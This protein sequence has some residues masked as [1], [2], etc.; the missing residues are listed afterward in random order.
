MLQAWVFGRSAEDV[1]KKLKEETEAHGLTAE[2]KN[3]TADSHL[4]ARPHLL[5]RVL[6]LALPFYLEPNVAIWRSET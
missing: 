2:G 6:N 4:N 5:Q 1:D 3:P